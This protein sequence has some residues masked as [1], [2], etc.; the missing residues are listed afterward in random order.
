MK[1]KLGTVVAVFTALFLISCSTTMKENPLLVKSNLKYEAP[2]FDKIEN[3]HFLPAFEEALLIARERV[4]KIANESDQPTFENTILALELSSIELG[5]VSSLFFPLNSSNTNDEMQKIALEVS[6]MVSAFGNDIILN[7]P[8][9]ERVKAVYEKREELGLN[10]EQ[11]RLTELSYKNFAR[12]GA[13]LKEEERERFREIGAELSKLSLQFGQNLLASTNAFTMHIT[14]STQLIGL[15]PFVVEAAANEATERELTGWLFTLQAPSFGPFLKYSENRPLREKIWKAYSG[16]ASEGEWDNKEIIKEI[17]TLRKEK[18]ALL[19]YP[20]HAA[21]VLADRM[22]KDVTTVETFL[23]NLLEAALPHAKNDV[24]QI[25]KYAKESGFN[26]VLM[27]WDFSYW[28]E[29][30]KS[31]KYAINDQILKPY[32]QLENVEHAVFDLAQRLYGLTF[33]EN[34]KLPTYHPDVKTYEVKDESG[35][36]ISLLYLDFFPRASKDGG[37]WMTSFRS[38]R[39]ID[40]IEERPFVTLVLNFTKPT[41]TTPSLLTFGEVVTLLHEFGHAL[42]GM[43][44]EGSYSSQTGTS[45]PR[46]FVELPS[47]ILENWAT[48]KEFLKSFALHYE[49]GEVIP[50]ELIDKVL[51]ARNF[52]AG[53][54]NVRQLSFGLIDMAW[55]TLETPE[56]VKD[57]MAFEKEVMKRTDVLPPVEGISFSQ[58]FGHIFSGGYSAGYYGYKWAEVLE[59]DAFSLFKERGIF[60]REVANSFRENILSKG[61]LEDADILFRKFRGRE[62]RVEA[63]LEKFGLTSNN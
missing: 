20:N 39:I 10:E 59:A 8:L 43:L 63:L 34:S 24:A 32:F 51:A 56:S 2:P 48:E 46:D 15:P 35:K 25:E 36:F 52:L 7:Q 60:S 40:G 29:K 22:A 50:D 53:Y 1:K 33:T 42:H 17:I 30:Y 58:T 12:N 27:P 61:N 49:T 26:E 14:D 21:Y 54:N 11:M 3:R 16:R 62:P 23:G 5:R 44:A 37:A 41:P 4:D 55:H 18:A 31:E 28:S 38:Q 19:G 57:V 47:Q 45:V 13:N 6:P 9:F